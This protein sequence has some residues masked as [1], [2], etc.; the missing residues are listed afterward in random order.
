MIG[1]SGGRENTY[2]PGQWLRWGR[3]QIRGF[4]AAGG[5]SDL[6]RADRRVGWRGRELVAIKVA[7]PSAG[8]PGA[9]AAAEVRL[10]REAMLLRLVSHWRVPRPIAAFREHGRAHLVLEFVHGQ[11]L[12]SLLREPN[13]R[14]RPPW[15]EPQVVALGRALAGL[16]DDLHTG[17]AGSDPIIVRD[18]KPGNL[19]VTP[20]GD[21]RLVDLGIASR[22]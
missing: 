19:I 3:Y 2:Q 6:Y 11:T 18:L 1:Q 15:P 14:L 7:R 16:L 4:H 12:E 5:M 17:A 20:R 21:V 8:D 9:L 10:A 22:S 13:S